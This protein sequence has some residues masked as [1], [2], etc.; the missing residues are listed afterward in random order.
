[1]HRR[2]LPV[3]TCA[4]ERPFYPKEAPV[5]K[6]ESRPPSYPEYY[7][8]R[9]HSQAP[10]RDKPKEATDRSRVKI[11]EDQPE[12]KPV[13]VDLDVSPKRYS[14]Y[15]NSKQANPPT[16]EQPSPKVQEPDTPLG[17]SSRLHQRLFEFG[18][19]S[20]NSSAKRVGLKKPVGDTDPLNRSRPDDS[21]RNLN[22]SHYGNI[23]QPLEKPQPPAEMP[24]YPKQ[25]NFGAR[26][27]SNGRVQIFEDQQ[28][29]N[30]GNE[31]N[32][33][34]NTEAQSTSIH[35]NNRRGYY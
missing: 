21:F 32:R 29:D 23:F 19:H 10:I 27:R 31:A 18:N 26:I 35:S 15:L 8:P 3:A 11:F 22:R 5:T 12:P 24:L 14:N 9:G 28:P 16:V 7:V 4:V 2:P 20:N 13:Y 33:P 1:V 6:I 25:Y 30:K 17:F 34:T